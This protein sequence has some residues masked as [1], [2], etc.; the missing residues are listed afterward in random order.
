MHI[1]KKPQKP[2]KKPNNVTIKYSLC[3]LCRNSEYKQNFIDELPASFQECCDIL[4]LDNSLNKYDGYSA[5]RKFLKNATTK[6]I[7]ICHDDVRLNGLSLHE[8]DTQIQGKERFDPS[9]RVF[10]IAGVSVNYSFPPIKY[11]HY[12]AHNEEYW[13]FGDD[14]RASS[15][16]EC[17]I[18]IRNE[19]DIHPSSFLKGFHFYASD[20]CI[21]AE[22]SGYSSYVIDFPVTHKSTGSLNREFFNSKDTFTKHLNK[23]GYHKKYATTCTVLY[24][25]S[26]TILKILSLAEDY[27]LYSLL[28][29][30][31]RDVCLKEVA[32]R[33]IALCGYAFYFFIFWKKIVLHIDSFEKI[34][35]RW[36]WNKVISGS[37][38]FNKVN[39]II[40]KL[41]KEKNINYILKLK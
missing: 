38:F 20:L 26:K 22:L 24:S 29:N 1:Y 11:G 28:S 41:K 34:I 23:I 10:G 15:L 33:G 31:R 35:I 39:G 13:G 7:I 19:L 32:T 25:G 37:F 21:N 12:F 30:E 5:A 36:Y 14:G 8:L 40:W 6:Y 18:I 17:F 9:A 2:Q 3:L 4:A 16:D 27:C